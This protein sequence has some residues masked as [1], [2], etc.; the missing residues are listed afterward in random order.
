ME[1]TRFKYDNKVEAVAKVYELHNTFSDAP[2]PHKDIPPVD[3]IVS[4]I[5]S[6]QPGEGLEATFQVKFSDT[7]YETECIVDVQIPK[8]RGV[9]ITQS[10]EEESDTH[11]I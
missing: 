1:T 10:R 11:S 4:E 3:D 2:A 7:Q 9:C 5:Y 8:N 6:L